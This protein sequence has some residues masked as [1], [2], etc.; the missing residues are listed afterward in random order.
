MMILITIAVM[1]EHHK[2]QDISEDVR[3]AQESN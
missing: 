1:I 2:I 3:R